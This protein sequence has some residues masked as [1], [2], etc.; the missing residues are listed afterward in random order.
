MEFMRDHSGLPF[1]DESQVQFTMQSKNEMFTTLDAALFREIGDPL[2]FSYPTD[3]PL[4]GELEEQM[5][6]LIREY[7][8]QG[9]YL[10]PHAPDEAGAHD[11]ACMML[12]L[13]CLGANR[14]G[15]GDILFL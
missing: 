11:D 7:V 10:S 6:A 1:D 5:T 15:I 2:R 3:H 13:D 4:A 14:A 9:E 12:A 8:G